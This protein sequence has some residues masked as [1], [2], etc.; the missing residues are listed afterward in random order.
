MF[1]PKKSSF[2]EGKKQIR[3]KPTNRVL[4]ENEAEHL[5]HPSLRSMLAVLWNPA[6]GQD[7]IPRLRRVRKYDR[8]QQQTQTKAGD[9]RR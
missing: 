4:V 2:M 9:P 3:Q 5:N 7:K 8:M 6:R 1:L